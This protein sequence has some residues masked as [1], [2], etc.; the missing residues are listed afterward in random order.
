MFVEVEWTMFMILYHVV[1]AY[2]AYSLMGRV[3]ILLRTAV[4]NP[5]HRGDS[6]RVRAR[7]QS[8]KCCWSCCVILSSLTLLF[9]PVILLDMAD[10]SSYQVSRTLA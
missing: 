9:H 5:A 1:R 7:H 4:V 6:A 8:E 10:T 2:D 3:K